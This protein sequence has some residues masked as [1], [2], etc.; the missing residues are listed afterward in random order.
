MRT[1]LQFHANP[2]DVY[3][4]VAKWSE[5]YS[6]SVVGES[7]FPF[8]LTSLSVREL[9]QSKEPVPAIRRIWHFL[10]PVELTARSDRE[11]MD[12]YPH[13]MS[14]LIGQWTGISG[15][16]LTEMR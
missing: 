12:M 14:V 16:S 5:E 15:T 3:S 13:G 1:S 9:Q 8:G 6:L 7:F 4:T 2:L 10:G 11:F